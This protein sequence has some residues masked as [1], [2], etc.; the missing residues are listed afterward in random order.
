MYMCDPS[1][2][3][4]QPFELRGRNLFKLTDAKPDRRAPMRLTWLVKRNGTLL[5]RL[6]YKAHSVH[7]AELTEVNNIFHI[8][9]FHRSGKSGPIKR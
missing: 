6:K 7:K 2:C 3:F 9:T 5:R 4:N 1:F 8:A